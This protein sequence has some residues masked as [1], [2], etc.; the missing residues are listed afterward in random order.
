[1]CCVSGDSFPPTSLGE[2]CLASMQWK[3]GKTP[4]ICYLETLLLRSPGH[5]LAMALLRGSPQSPC[6]RLSTSEAAAIGRREGEGERGREGGRGG[7]AAG[8]RGRGAEGGEEGDQGHTSHSAFPK[9]RH[10]DGKAIQIYLIRASRRESR[11]SETRL[12][13]GAFHK[14]DGNNCVEMLIIFGPPPPHK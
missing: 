6:C 1:M 11:G 3:G 5:M 12:R 14:P 10:L 8:Q 9:I 7:R 4:C 13:I 2:S